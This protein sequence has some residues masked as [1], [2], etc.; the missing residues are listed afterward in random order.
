MKW[1]AV[2]KEWEK[3]AIK[4]VFLHDEED[5]SWADI[6]RK[7]CISRQRAQQ[8]YQKQVEK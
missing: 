8:I 5:M 4:I 7:F 6:G 2:K 1:E 3:R